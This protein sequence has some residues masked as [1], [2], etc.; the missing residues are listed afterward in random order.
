MVKVQNDKLDYVQNEITREARNKLRL[1]WVLEA[2]EYE[3]RK[4]LSNLIC[5]IY[6][7]R[8]AKRNGAI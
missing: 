2:P 5:E 3:L 4:Y 7:K 6:E 1:L 8:M